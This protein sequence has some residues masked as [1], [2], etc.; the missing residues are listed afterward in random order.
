MIYHL[1]PKRVVTWT[2]VFFLC[3]FAVSAPAGSSD[4]D[5]EE[6]SGSDEITQNNDEILPHYKGEGSFYLG[7]R[8]VNIDTAGRSAEYEDGKSSIALG[9][10]G[11]ACPLPHRYHMHLE[12]FG[13]HN[14]YADFGYAYK[15]L[16]LFRNVFVGIHHNLDHYNY[17]YPGDPPAVLFEDRSPGDEN[18]VDF[19]KNE[20]LLRAKA[21]DFPLH[22][23]AKHRYVEREGILEQR[24]LAG[25]IGNLI[26]TSESRD[27][28]WESNDLTLG[29]NSHLGPVEVEFSRNESTFDPGTGSVLYDYFP[30]STVFGRPGDTYPHNVVPETESSGNTIRFHSSFTGQIVASATLSNAE[31][32]NNYSGAESDGWKAAMDLRWIP[33]PVV[34]LFF[35]YRH[36]EKD[37]ENPEQVVLSGLVNRITYPVRTPISTEKDLFSLSARYRP[38]NKLTLIGNYEFE[39]RKRTD[40]DDW[41]VLP[42]DSDVHR[43]N[44]TAHARPL[45]TLKLKAIYDYEAYANPS[46]N[47]EPD[48]SNKIRLNATYTPVGWITVFCDYSLR[49]MQREELQYLQGNELVL[50]EDGERDGRMDRFLGSLSLLFSPEV[51]LTAS[52]AYNRRKIEQ[53]LAYTLWSTT[54][55]GRDLPYYD[56]GVPYSDESNTFILSLYYLLRKD[57]T[58][59]ADLSYTIAEGEYLP[60]DVIAGNSST[61]GSF[62]AM[63]TTETMVTVGLAKKILQDWEVGVSFAA[64]FFEDRFNDGAGVEQDDEAFITTF[65]VKRYF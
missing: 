12:Y 50:L 2:L 7:F 8:A 31:N 29:M 5:L 59:T 62:S 61:L 19:I 11:L 33:D 55:A 25:S 1:V 52:W 37:K 4:A 64:D 20:L 3:G 54:G 28:N 43:I 41:I 24:F 6:S 10:D 51:T 34:S 49:L 32:T 16:L 56:R 48:H 47:T 42:A 9:L 36:Q 13:E 45:N 65:T 46:Y 30:S 44:L 58:L 53:D 40:I 38:L 18:Y 17:L 60:G 39:H 23:F 27:I 35:K 57:L 21:P 22:V 26:K 15:D 14:N 63:E